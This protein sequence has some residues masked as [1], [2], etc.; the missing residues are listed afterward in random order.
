MA[1]LTDSLEED[2]LGT[3]E[4]GSNFKESLQIT[5]NMLG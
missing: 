2:E 5:Q 3:G 1:S 4:G